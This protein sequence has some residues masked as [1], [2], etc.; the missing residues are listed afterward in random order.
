MFDVAIAIRLH[1]YDME[2]LYATDV[3]KEAEAS[4]PLRRRKP[5]EDREAA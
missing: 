3:L 4:I 5:N 1:E 2:S